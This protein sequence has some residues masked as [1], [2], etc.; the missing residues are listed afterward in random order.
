[1]ECKKGEDGWP[2]VEGAE[3]KGGACDGY[4]YTPGSKAN[5]EYCRLTEE[6]ADSAQCWEAG[7]G[8]R[9]HCEWDWQCPG[10]YCDNIGAW[11][12]NSGNGRCGSKVGLGGGCEK[13]AGCQSGLRCFDGTCS[14]LVANNVGANCADSSWCQSPGGC[15]Y[16][17]K[18]VHNT[19][20]TALNLAHGAGCDVDIQCGPGLS[21]VWWFDVIGGKVGYYCG[22]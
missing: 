10:G 4:C 15:Y 8:R 19:C 11:G 22:Y 3:C 7:D 13:D 6:C 20:A 12:F 5:W 9:C 18:L 14:T 21:C 2:C 1:W 16:S 17:G